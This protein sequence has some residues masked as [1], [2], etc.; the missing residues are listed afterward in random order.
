MKR[1]TGATFREGQIVARARALQADMYPNS[2]PYCMFFAL[3]EFGGSPNPLGPDYWNAMRRAMTAALREHA[4]RF[5]YVFKDIPFPAEMA[6]YLATAL[7]DLS[8]GEDHPLFAKRVLSGGRGNLRS[9]VQQESIDRAVDY[10]VAVDI[11]RIDDKRS[12]ATVADE[13][14]VTR[15]QVQRWVALRGAKGKREKEFRQRWDRKLARVHDPERTL[16][17][18]VRKSMQFASAD[19]RKLRSRRSRPK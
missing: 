7:E 12:R 15:K 11:G 8:E 9:R 2:W 14:G 3:W 6:S 13:F 1:R 10:L 16:V 5:K 19:Y 18:L 4:E 17:R